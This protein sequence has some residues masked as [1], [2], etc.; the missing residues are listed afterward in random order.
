M[1]KEEIRI[2]AWDDCAFRFEQKS[3]LVI[4][5]IFRGGKFLDGLLSTRIKKDGSDATDKIADSITKSRHYDQLSYIMLDGITFG[6]F[7]L[8][9]IKKLYKKT[10]MPI[11]IIQRSEPDMKKFKGALRIFKDYRKRLQIV[12]HAGKIFR[13][14]KIYY[15]K[16]GLT[17]D[18]C[19][20]LL[21]ITC[22]R[23]NIPE[24]VRVAHL[25]ASGLSGES[26]GRA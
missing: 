23:S 3:V 11:V 9:D 22:I 21:K 7:N 17:N 20:E 19:K 26:K 16:I 4:G 5:A 10:K 6:G 25:I 2:I 8:V 24:P 14:N 12:K 1:I 15:Q 18:E 13:F